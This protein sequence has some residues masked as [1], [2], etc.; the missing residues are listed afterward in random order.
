MD[1]KLT[2]CLAH[3]EIG[4]EAQDMVVQTLPPFSDSLSVKLIDLRAALMN[5]S[6]IWA[7]IFD[8]ASAAT[9]RTMEPMVTSFHHDSTGT[10]LL[11]HISSPCPHRW[12]RVTR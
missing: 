4:I 11:K 12:G 9:T 1:R 10:T 7:G 6:E 2:L 5:G 8:L 3:L